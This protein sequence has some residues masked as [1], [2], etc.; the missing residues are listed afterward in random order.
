MN[1]EKLKV[2]VAGIEF[3]NP[4]I[5]ASGTVGYGREY[6]QFFPLNILGAIS[7]KG[8]TKNKKLGN[9][10]PRIA[11]TP[12]G[13]LNS[14]GL[15]N[16]G[17]KYYIKN[18]LPY[19]ISKNATVIANIAGGSYN[20][21]AEIAEILEHTNVCAIELNIS[22]PNVKKGGMAFGSNAKTVEELVYLVRQKT[23]KPLIVKLSPNVTSITEIAKAAQEGGADALTLINT[24]LG[25][26][27]DIKTRRPILKN[28][29][30]GLSGPCILP[31]A[32]RMVW[33]T[34]KAVSIQIIGCGGIA[35]FEDALEVIMAGASMFQVG[36]AFFKNPCIAIKI[37]EDLLLWLNDNN[38]ENISELC[39]SV[40]DWF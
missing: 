8:T 29:V 35:S 32:V 12:G 9:P 7:I 34:K 14:I 21:Y 10:A 23:T 36:T 5:A 31:I 24:L 4:L 1:S 26:K 30:G 37:L 39:G 3:K 20:E 2:K 11:E 28:N 17:V 19:L 22:C 18:H 6:E 16:L 33:Q 27:I 25:M 38:I 13:M 40:L 15:E